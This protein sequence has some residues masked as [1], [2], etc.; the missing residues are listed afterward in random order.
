MKREENFNKEITIKKDCKRLNELMTVASKIEFP[1]L[2]MG[3]SVLICEWAS[4]T[5][6][7]EYSAG[8]GEDGDV[9]VII[10]SRSCNGVLCV[11]S[12]N[13]LLWLII[14]VLVCVI[15]IL[16]YYRKNYRYLP[17]TERKRIDDPED[18]KVENKE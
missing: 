5:G 13:W 11:E 14:I 18:R 3:S 8:S 2:S 4:D 16:L 1:D 7:K 10:K 12:S 6:C 17:I 15:I 9:N